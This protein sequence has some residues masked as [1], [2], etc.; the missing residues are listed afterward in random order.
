MKICNYIA[1]A[2]A[3][4]LAV[5][6]CGHKATINGEIKGAPGSDVIVKLLNV[7]VFTVL[8]TVKTNS[9]GAFRYDVD[10]TK[11][12]PEFIYLFHG[13]TKIASLLLDEGDKVSVTA[14]TLG[15]YQVEGSTESALLQQVEND[16]S[17]FA[18]G[19]S[20]LADKA[21]Q[22]GLSD[23]EKKQI[24]ADLGSEYVKYYRKAMKYVMEHSHSLTVVPV[25]FQQINADFPVFSQQTDAIL[26]ANICDS[27]KTVYPESRYVAALSK[28]A[29]SR[30]NGL[31]MS[32]RI[33]NAEERGFP[34]LNLPNEKGERV[35]LSSLKGDVILVHF[36]TSVDA[37][38]KIFNVEKILP[39]Y[40]KYHSRGFDVYEVSV[41]T[42]KAQWASVVK[43]QNLPWTNVCDGLGS[44]S[45]ALTLF[46]ILRVPTSVLIVDGQIYDKPISS[47]AELM[48]LLDQKLK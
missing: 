15:N 28:E 27:L 12:Q 22:T 33:Q 36:W 47:D 16:F 17:S 14:D 44:L 29:E 6:S 35:A 43:S 21:V 23:A 45:P 13:D 39:V 19:F 18:V 42:D 9:N 25:L 1:V 11:G 4:V 48:R 3:T 37:S 41:D 7:N 10:V 8:D 26:F 46:A 5:S 40:E 31:D 32:Y 30:A 38:Q 34:D 20:A 24:Q 2:L